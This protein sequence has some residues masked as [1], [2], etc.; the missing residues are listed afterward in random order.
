MWRR[1]VVVAVLAGFAAGCSSGTGEVDVAGTVTLDGAP[2]GAGN[3]A[4]IRF[5]PADGKGR[6]ADGF[7]DQGAYAVKLPAGAYKVS[8]SWMKPTG[9]KLARPGMKGPGSERDEAVQ[10]VPARYNTA[11]ELKAD[12]AAGKTKHDFELKK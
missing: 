11:T 8:V 12:V 3:E 10:A 7:V 9:K 4:V 5:D 2:V 1:A 6:P